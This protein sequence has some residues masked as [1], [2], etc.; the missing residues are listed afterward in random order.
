MRVTF[1]VFLFLLTACSGLPNTGHDAPK[2]DSSK[3]EGTS[4]LP[5]DIAGGFGLT[6]SPEEDSLPNPM[7]NFACSL[8]NAKGEKFKETTNV[9]LDLMVYVQN[10]IVEIF[11]PGNDAASS[12][13]FTLA[14][15]DLLK[16]V[17]SAKIID[18]GSDNKTIADKSTTLKNT[19][20]TDW[21]DVTTN[22]SG[23]LSN[24]IDSPSRCT[25]KEERTNILWSKPQ[26]GVEGVSW[27]DAKAACDIY[28]YDGEA[29]WRLPTADELLYAT[30]NSILLSASDDWISEGNMNQLYWSV[31]EPSSSEAYRANLASGSR[32][33]GP[34]TDSY[35]FVCVKPPPSPWQDLTPGGSCANTP[36]K[37]VYKLSATNT[38]YSAVLTAGGTATW[39]TWDEA[40]TVCQNYNPTGLDNPGSWVL[41]SMDQMRQAKLNGIKDIPGWRGSSDVTNAFWSSEQ[42]SS[43]VKIFY[44]L[45]GNDGE[46]LSTNKYQVICVKAPQ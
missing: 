9:K 37:C 31:D 5:E 23:L 42:S 19:V 25:M 38:L 33:W 11:K 22:A 17:I 21:R 10:Q 12:F 35:G 32:Y 13:K 7:V 14:R 44:F 15:Q 27:S 34:K 39:K 46:G 16:V 45:Y 29:G 28:T 1:M 20:K 8:V 4:E 24:C 18:T 30:R 3:I 6:C 2:K 40:K 36:D 41:P 26:S 43:L